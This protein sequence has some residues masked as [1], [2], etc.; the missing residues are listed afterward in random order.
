MLEVHSI[1]RDLLIIEHS[2]QSSTCPRHLSSC[3]IRDYL[4]CIFYVSRVIFIATMA[5]CCLMLISMGFI[6]LNAHIM[7]LQ[8]LYSFLRNQTKHLFIS[9][10]LWAFIAIVGID[11]SLVGICF[12]L[13]CVILAKIALFRLSLPHSGCY[14]IT[15]TCYS[16]I[17]TIFISFL[18]DHTYSMREYRF[19]AFI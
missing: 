4:Y 19:N 11:F 12:H 2:C 9:T 10:Y 1:S 8:N 7:Q 14:S 18:I 16:F 5:T 6:C 17:A 13:C 3:V 15:L